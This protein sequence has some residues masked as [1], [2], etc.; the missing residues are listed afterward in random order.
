MKFTFRRK[1]FRLLFRPL[2]A[3]GLS[4][5]IVEPEEEVAVAASTNASVW[6]PGRVIVLT[7]CSV[8]EGK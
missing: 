5:E 1:L 4:F 3:I 8:S 2:A 6:G 7:L